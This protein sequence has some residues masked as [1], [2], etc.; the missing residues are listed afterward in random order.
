MRKTV[1]A[2]EKIVSRWGTS[3]A[4]FFYDC[5]GEPVKIDLRNGRGQSRG[6]GTHHTGG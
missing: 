1:E 3:E 6:R 5:E 2:G 4:K